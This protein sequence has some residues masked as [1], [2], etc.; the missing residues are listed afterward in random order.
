MTDCVFCKIVR[1]EAPAEIVE[2]W[3]QA[4]AIRPL[5]PVTEGHILVIPNDHVEDFTTD[6]VVT[7]I[8]AYYAAELAARLGGEWNLITSAGPN[9]TQT[10]YHLHVHL[11]P[12]RPGDGLHL[13][14]TKEEGILARLDRITE[15]LDD[16]LDA[17]SARTETEVTTLVDPERV[18]TTIPGLRH[19]GRLR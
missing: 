15:I 11:V 2:Q 4:I 6:S 16:I 13:P 9:A 19:Q 1:H 5:N 10:V 14:W 18:Y 8:T 3:S 7:E 12:R 17:R